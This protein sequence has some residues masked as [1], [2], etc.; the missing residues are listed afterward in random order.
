MRRGR[1]AAQLLSGGAA[2]RDPVPVTRRI[3][4]VQAQDPRGARLAL[5]A[6]SQG[7][8]AADVDR[9]LTDDR[10]LVI[11]TLNR[12]TLHL[13]ASED[14]PWLQALLGPPLHAAALRRLARDGVGAHAA[15]RA[16]GVL[17]RVLAAEGPRTR[18]QAR[19]ALERADMPAA[20][21]A[22][23]HVVFLAAAR[24]LVLRGP[25]IGRQ[26]AFVLAR[27]WLGPPP[28]VDR[29]RA[30]AELARRYLAGH[31]P[32]SERDLAYWTGL[33][34]RDARAALVAIAGS[35]RERE[36]GLLELRR[37]SAADGRHPGELPPPRLLGPFDPVLH[38]WRS[39]L[40][41]TGSYDRAVVTGGV[42]R[43]FALVG[44]RALALWRIERGDVVIEPFA[45]I[46][47]AEMAALRADGEAVV[48][49]LHE[50]GSETS[51]PSPAP[52]PALAS[53]SSAR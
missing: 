8:R 1:F 18:V 5:R 16:L 24:G 38:G 26:H 15:E 50:P 37:K 20:A 17:E 53:P 36:D 35:L 27:D 23:I 33:P 3:L 31:A 43:A 14:Y 12:G 9:A 47:G 21:Q 44:G 19:E 6:R 40:W 7:L 29:D 48:R 10:S 46:R 39:R 42:F 2:G 34:L 45:R 51:P 28:A 13:V 11:T 52:P 32:A 4:A 30:L 41:V 49:Y 22:L 25:M